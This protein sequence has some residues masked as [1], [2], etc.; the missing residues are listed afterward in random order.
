M[1]VGNSVV[2]S[3]TVCLL[4][5]F[6]SAELFRRFKYPNILGY[7]FAGIVFGLPGIRE[8]LVPEE[9][10]GLLDFLS[11]IGIVFFLLLAGADMDL[12][13]L[14]SLS[15]P[16]FLVGTLCFIFPLGAGY[17]F[18]SMAG[19]SSL[20]SFTIALCLSVTAAAVAV[21]IL[22]EYDLLKT[23]EGTVI[24]GGS[25]VDDIW[26]IFSLTILLAFIEVQS[27]S[28]SSILAVFSRLYLEYLAFFILA[29]VIGFKIYPYLARLVYMEKTEGGVFT[30]SI[31][32]G[33]VITLLSEVFGLSSLIGAFIAGLI[34]NRNIQSK[35]EGRE[36]ISNLKAVTFGLIMPFFFISMGLKF[37][38]PAILSD[39]PLLFALA[40]IAFVGKYAGAIVSGYLTGLNWSSINSVGLGMNDRGG[41]ELIIAVVAVTHELINDTVFSVVLSMSFIT[42]FISL[43]LFKRQVAKN[44][45]QLTPLVD[46]S[47]RH[48]GRKKC[49]LNDV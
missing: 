14:R 37:S 32:F 2:F 42:T 19:F 7:I 25:V 39:L 6:L 41:I 27:P 28:I 3:F 33:L 17:L 35:K 49:G 4:L 38:F 26:G 45:R 43:Y 13:R 5:S 1:D 16:S 40:L 29:Y 46:D 47:I 8:F 12:K 22:M 44:M 11:N 18:L 10:S 24:V 9:F 23:L 30:L 20:Q 31:A 48:C 21:E 15:T 34:I 36:I